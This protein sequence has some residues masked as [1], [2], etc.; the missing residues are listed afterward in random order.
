MSDREQRGLRGH[1]RSCTEEHNY[2]ARTDAEGKTYP[3]IQ[4]RYTTE[5]DAEGRLLATGHHNPDG[6][7]WMSCLSYD[8][9][10]RLLNISSGTE[11]QMKQTAY[12]YD[13]K[14]RLQAIKDENKPDA[15][16]FTY[17]ERGT[18]TKTEISRPEDY[19][20]NMAFAGSPFEV[21]SRAPNILGGG[22]ATTFYD[23]QGRATE[24]RVH[25]AE[26]ELIHRAVR[27]YDADGHVAEEQ[28]I[29]DKLENLIPAEHR[30]KM[31][32]QS[33]LSADELTQELRAQLT[34]LMS[35]QS[36]HSVAYR[37]DT[38][39]RVIHTTRR[40]FNTQ[41]EIDT[42]YN[43]HGDIESQ[44]ERSTRSPDSSTLSEARHSYMYDQ[45]GNWTEK[46]TLHRSSPEAQFQPL[47][48]VK[49][50]LVY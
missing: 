1:V 42:I 21:S 20:P 5:F 38:Q 9:S 45:H 32:E 7:N 18:K 40:V 33:G 39:G 25:N 46:M 8:N 24:V 49:R 15:T 11:G 10:G 47:P 22:T 28:Q 35:G 41:D 2:P 12:L 50:T 48:T 19:R 43:E 36:P 17:N 13:E 31:L 44:I 29:V 30:A 3:P 6:S 27:T 26:G 14:G 4:T 16:T 37:R 23:E 34:K